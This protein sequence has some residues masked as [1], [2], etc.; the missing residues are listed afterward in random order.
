MAALE[1][2]VPAP[3]RVGS[4]VLADTSAWVVSRRVPELRGAFDDLVVDG[5]VA[6]CDQVALE[7]LYSTQ[8]HAEFHARRGQLSTLPQCPIGVP[9]WTRALDVFEHLSALGPLHHRQVKIADLLI[10][11]AGEAAELEVLHY[12]RDFDVIAGVT[13]QAARWIAPAGEA[14]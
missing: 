4:R 13:G 10:A 7:L 3:R 8:D 11:A 14:G 2:S 1:A 12:D 5:R 6:M 9:E